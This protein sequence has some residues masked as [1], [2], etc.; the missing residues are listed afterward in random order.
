MQVIKLG[1]VLVAVMLTGC[2][3]REVE[4]VSDPP[5]ATVS[6]NG[7]P[8]GVTPKKHWQTWNKDLMKETTEAHQFTFTLDGYAPYVVTVPYTQ[9]E[10]DIRRSLVGPM[11]IEA[12]LAPLSDAIELTIVTDP[13]DAQITVAGGPPMQGSGAGVQVTLPFSRASGSS[14]Y[15]SIPIVASRSDYETVTTS[16]SRDWALGNRRLHLNLPRIRETFSVQITSNP[17]GATL[18]IDHETLG[19]IPAGGR[20]ATITLTRRSARDAW[21]TARM[22]VAAPDCAPMIAEVTYD[23]LKTQRAFNFALDKVEQAMRIRVESTPEGAEVLLGGTR[24]GRTPCDVA[25]RFT[26]SSRDAE[27]SALNLTLSKADHETVVRLVSPAT[28]GEGGTLRVALPLLVDRIPVRVTTDPVGAIVRL[29][30]R[31]IGPS[32]CQQEIVFTRTGGSNPWPSVSIDARQL[33]F[34]PVSDVISYEHLK[35]HSGQIHLTLPRILYQE[36]DITTVVVGKG[37]PQLV[38][39]SRETYLGEIAGGA[40]TAAAATAM[41]T[42]LLAAQQASIHDSALAVDPTGRLLFTEIDRASGQSRLF[43][44]EAGGIR[45]VTDP[46]YLDFDPTLTRDGRYCYFA[47]TRAGNGRVTI[48]RTEPGRRSGVADI[49]SRGT[50]L[51]DVEPSVSPD[52]M[53]LAYTTYP[54]AN[55]GPFIAITKADGSGAERRLHSGRHPAFSPDG[56]LIA[57]VAPDA[58][59]YLQIW[60]IGAEAGEPPTMR[61]ASEANHRHPAWT[62]DGRG[63]VFEADRHPRPGGGPQYDIFHQILDTGELLQL[64]NDPSHDSRPVVTHDGRTVIFLSNRGA[65]DP[66]KPANRI[67]S[68]PLPSK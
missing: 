60:T 18:K 52:G 62:P 40:M 37:P 2:L 57:F 30:D 26:R 24:V 39:E 42:P 12:R 17:P 21:P 11:R 65:A 13:P 3:G 63:L 31:E 8:I 36:V 29:A 6:V 14:P 66:T 46:G 4:F 54:D 51:A 25:L 67:F 61:T 58:R 49:T 43:L 53:W 41:A 44:V 35:A 27:W 28:P 38:H 15:Q 64:T 48:W 55:T 9:V 16:V 19:S 56:K 32:P 1:A 59:G 33:G 5:G 45:S 47:S 22:E 50:S 68:V 7:R 23:Q 10:S 34:E 20:Q